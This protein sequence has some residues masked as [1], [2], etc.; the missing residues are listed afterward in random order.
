MTCGAGRAIN[1]WQSTAYGTFGW[2]SG[3][4]LCRPYFVFIN[5]SFVIDKVFEA[6]NYAASWAR[7][8]REYSLRRFLYKLTD[9]LALWL[10][11]LGYSWLSLVET[12]D[13]VVTKRT[14]T[15]FVEAKG[16]KSN[17]RPSFG[18]VAKLISVLGFTDCVH[19]RSAVLTGVHE[20][21]VWVKPLLDLLE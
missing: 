18:H 4:G 15:T 9:I 6:S 16:T 3:R 11:L 17:N 12:D 1:R 14:T 7:N 13:S 21:V 5:F 20:L 19:F 2:V 8:K 10:M